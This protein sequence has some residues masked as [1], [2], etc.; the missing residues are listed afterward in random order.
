[1]HLIFEFMV[2]QSC[3]LPSGWGRSRHISSR[4]ASSVAPA[5]WVF[6]SLRYINA[7]SA[8]TAMLKE[9]AIK[10]EALHPEVSAKDIRVG[11][12]NDLVNAEGKGTTLS[13]F[14]TVSH[15]P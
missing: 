11:S 2:S 13:L 3:M 15:I 5:S 14:V 8:I 1:M 6:P 12:C 7:A 9:L 10:V 4:T